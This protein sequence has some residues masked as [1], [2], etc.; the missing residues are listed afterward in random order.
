MK[1]EEEMSG[2]RLPKEE[3]RKFRE[4]SL[5]EMIERQIK[6]TRD[7]TK[8]IAFAVEHAKTAIDAED[9]AYTKQ[10]ISDA[11]K[12]VEKLGKELLYAQML[13]W[14]LMKVREDE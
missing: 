4:R 11:K 9:Y 10:S 5:V 6:R 13:C 3:E 7:I 1:E 14:D 12:Q 2:E 8:E